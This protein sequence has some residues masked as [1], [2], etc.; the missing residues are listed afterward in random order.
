VLALRVTDLAPSPGT[1][2]RFRSLLIEQATEGE[3]TLRR[4]DGAD[5]RARFAAR[6]ATVAGI[7]LYVWVGFVEP[8]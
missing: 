5:V 7:T 8:G 6:Q 2:D 4:K 3:S 1:P